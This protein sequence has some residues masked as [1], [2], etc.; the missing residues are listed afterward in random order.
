V[1]GD[2]S[3]P[4]SGASTVMRGLPPSG[5]HPEILKTAEQ[6]SGRGRRR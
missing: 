1:S 2:R 4:R 6:R 5:F 3:L